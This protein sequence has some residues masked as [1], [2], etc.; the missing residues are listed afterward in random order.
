MSSFNKH[1]LGDGICFTN[2][3]LSNVNRNLIK[4]NTK[5]NTEALE[6]GILQILEGCLF[7]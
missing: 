6:N 4:V 1:I 3:S 7:I 2:Q 5:E